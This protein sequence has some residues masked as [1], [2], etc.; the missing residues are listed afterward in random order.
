MRKVEEGQGFMASGW[1]IVVD[2][3]KIDKRAAEQG[4][5]LGKRS[6]LAEMNHLTTFQI[7]D[8]RGGKKEVRWLLSL[9]LV[10]LADSF[11]QD[12]FP[13]S[14]EYLKSIDEPLETRDEFGRSKGQKRGRN[15]EAK[16][17]QQAP[18]PVTEVAPAPE[19]PSDQAVVVDGAAA[20]VAPAIEG[21]STASTSAVPSTETAPTTA[22]TMD[23]DSQPSRSYV[24]DL[25]PIRA[26]EKRRLDFKGKLW[27]APLTTVGNLPF[28][29]IAVENGCDITVSEMGLSQE[30]L[31]GN[32]NEWS[33]VRRC[34]VS[35]SSLRLLPSSFPLLSSRLTSFPRRHPIERLFGVQI[36]GS[37]PQMLVP[38]AEA[39]VKNAEIDFL[40]SSIFFS[41]LELELTLSSTQTSTA[42]ARSTSSSTRVPD[43]P[44]S[45]TPENSA[46]R[47]SVCRRFSVRFLSRSRSV[48]VSPTRNRRRT[49][50][51]RGC[52]RSGQ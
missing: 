36:A 2:Q 52:R 48:R 4:E 11:L 43:P 40:G 47:S 46:S 6:Q 19:A 22:T 24:P 31:S 17:E 51:C 21:D 13:L 35:P 45:L 42:A 8:I 32:A 50:L 1:E 44:S 15:G 49:S 18:T 34:V 26:C 41:C 37:K 23:V 28:R 20:P 9:L 33:L 3:E 25:A 30:F 27:M 10:L 14:C 39:I 5:G 16:K 38:A 7:K 29:R 12:K